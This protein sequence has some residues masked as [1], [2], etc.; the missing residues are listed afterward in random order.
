MRKHRNLRILRLGLFAALAVAAPLSAQ[1]ERVRVT[2][3]VVDSASG[4]PVSGA[5]VTLSRRDIVVADRQ[6]HFDLGRVPT[7]EQTFVAS[8][9]GYEPV[10]VTVPVAETMEP[11]RVVLSANPVALAEIRVQVDR[12]ASRRRSAATSVRVITQADMGYGVGL[13][14]RNYIMQRAFLSQATCRQGVSSLYAG[15]S[16][17]RSR[18]ME[19]Q[20]MVYI[21][22][23][24]SI[25]GLDELGA[26]SPQEIYMVEIYGGGREVRVYTN[27]FM[28]LSAR[29]HMNP[30]P[31]GV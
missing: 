7:G 24:R 23:R 9:L 27:W 4:Q 13:D 22:E 30:M 16:C 2:G 28:Q 17:I 15:G 21:D 19:V 26:Y 25:A 31:L 3:V 5:H 6:G 18:G 8:A 29:R 20:P 1:Q 11:V 12:L 10:I 14:A